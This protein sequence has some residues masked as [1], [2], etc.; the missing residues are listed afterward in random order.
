MAEIHVQKLQ[1]SN[2]RIVFVSFSDP[3]Y[4]TFNFLALKY[5]QHTHFNAKINRRDGQVGVGGTYAMMGRV[6]FLENDAP[7]ET[8]CCLASAFGFLATDTVIFK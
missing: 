6:H 2:S 8:A 3:Y 4:S 7:V 1:H 5:R